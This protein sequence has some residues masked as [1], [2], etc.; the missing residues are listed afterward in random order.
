ML[1]LPATPAEHVPQAARHSVIF[2]ISFYDSFY[3][4]PLC[5]CVMLVHC[6][7][8]VYTIHDDDDDITIVC[9][10]ESA[11]VCVTTVSSGKGLICWI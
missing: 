1:V 4:H 5:Y 9:L 10:M 11:G 7:L 6:V 2:L 3:H 8:C